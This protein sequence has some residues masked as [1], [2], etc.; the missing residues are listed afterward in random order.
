MS[1]PRFVPITPVPLVLHTRE[2]SRFR[3]RR[4][5]R[6]GGPIV[7]AVGETTSA[8]GEQSADDAPEVRRKRGRPRNPDA[9]E[10]ILSAAADLILARGFD[11]MTVDDVAAQA[12]VGKATVYRRWA[13]KEDLAVAAMERLYNS[14]MPIPDTGNIQRDLVEAY[15]NV[16]AFANSVAGESYLRTTIAESVRDVR[17]AALY[18]HASERVEVHAAAMFEKAI[19]RGELRE[20]FDV[21]NA[22]QWMT[23]LLAV[24]VITHRPMPKVD[25]APELV[26]MLL[27]GISA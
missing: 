10:R 27:H 16:L 8:P 1:P 17:I 25:Q 9:D 2:L 20:G 14:E 4:Q 18:R 3:V 23:G 11:S 21:P 6:P 12:H 7:S 19:Q 5:Q 26:R 24:C 15:T 13:R 22:V